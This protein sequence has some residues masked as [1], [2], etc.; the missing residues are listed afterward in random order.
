M[1]GIAGAVLIA[2]GLVGGALAG[3][4]IDKTK[5]FEETAKVS[6]GFAAISCCLLA[7]VSRNLLVPLEVYIGKLSLVNSASVGNSLTHSFIHF[8]KIEMYFL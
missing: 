6:Y 7:I 1:A 3:V 5:K 2:V 4:Y 8:K